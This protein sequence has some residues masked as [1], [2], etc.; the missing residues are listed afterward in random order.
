M[1]ARPAGYRRPATAADRARAADRRADKLAAMHSQLRAGIAALRSGED[2]RR[3]LRLAGR[4]P[5]YSA[6]NVM[7]IAAQRPDATRVCGYEGWRALGRQVR[8]GEKG[9][10]IL[11]PVLRADRDH[12]RGR[13]HDQGAS[14]AGEPA[15]D[16]GAET[17]G[18]RRLAGFRPAYVFDVSQTDGDDLPEQPAPRLL[19]GAAPAGL[20]DALGALA[21]ARGFTVERGDCGQ[22]NGYTHFGDRRIRVRADVDPAQA[23][24]TLAHELGHVLIH[25]PAAFAGT[26]AGCRGTVEVEAESVAYLVAGDAGLDAAAYSFPYVAHWA[27]G[28]DGRRPEDVVTATAD[29]VLHAARV[30][31]DSWQPPATPTATAAAALTAGHA[32]AGRE[33]SREVGRTAAH[34]QRAATVLAGDQAAAATQRAGAARGLR[35]RRRLLHRPARRQLRPRLPRGGGAW[36]PS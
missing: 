10:A 28:V 5:T 6:H 15:P 20:W 25:D 27:G 12:D 34:L 21:A 14:R 31:V 11:A 30:I 7:L 26:T 35:G 22:A 36:P 9:I 24:K 13:D 32:Q 16:P 3:W 19:A 17:A 2:W 23:V 18:G 33:R 8:K 4:F 29:R 1:A